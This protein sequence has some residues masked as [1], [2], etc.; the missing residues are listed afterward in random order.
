MMHV[1]VVSKL[2]VT[3]SLL[4]AVTSHRVFY[5]DTD[6]SYGRFRDCL[7]FEPPTESMIESGERGTG[8]IGYVSISRKKGKL[9]FIL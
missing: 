1:V 4:N 3:F 2:N 6:G 7:T 8:V 9:M 5:I